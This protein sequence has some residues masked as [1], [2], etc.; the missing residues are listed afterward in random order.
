MADGMATL[1]PAHFVPVAIF[2]CVASLGGGACL[3]GGEDVA[4]GEDYGWIESNLTAAQR[5]TRAAQIRDAAAAQRPHAYGVLALAGI[6]HAETGLEPLLVRG[7]RGPARDPTRADCGGGP[8][9]RRRGRRSLRR[10]AKAASACSSST[11]ARSTTPSVAT[12]AIVLLSIAGNVS[13][14]VDSRRR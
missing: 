10:C 7:A 8:V 5:R 4:M 14:A 6:A 1:R 2:L 11:P 12:G 9:D 3:G 13:H